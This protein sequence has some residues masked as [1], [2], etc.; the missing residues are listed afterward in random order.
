[1]AL[2]WIGA[3]AQGIGNVLGFVGNERTNAA[4]LKIAREQMAFN[5]DEAKK[6]R[7]WQSQQTAIQNE[8]NS[9]AAQKARL[10]AAGINPY[11]ADI[12]TGTGSAASGGSAASAPTA[13]QMRPF[14]F[15]GAASGL[16]ASILQAASVNKTNAEADVIRKQGVGLEIENQFAYQKQQMGILESIGRLRESL[17]RSNVNDEQRKYVSQQIKDLQQQYD[18]NKETWESRKS[19]IEKQNNLLESQKELALRDASLRSAQI[20]ATQ[21]GVRLSKSQ[22]ASLA[23]G[24]RESVQKMAL[25]ASQKNL[26][27]NEAKVKARE[28]AKLYLEMVGIS[29]Q[30]ALFPK[31]ARKLESEIYSNYKNHIS[32][33]S[34]GGDV[35]PSDYY[36]NGGFIPK[37]FHLEPNK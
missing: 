9:P 14:D 33:F 10:Q 30:N 23:Q 1:M 5:S 24:I 6:Q 4:N 13:P 22:Q 19:Q 25:L 11:L 7:D 29:N 18:W 32:G 35:I 26:T 21:E 3:A 20:L 16:G 34:M 27:D 17:S 15:V 37:G 2:E 36:E 12:S 28:N 31:L 8:F